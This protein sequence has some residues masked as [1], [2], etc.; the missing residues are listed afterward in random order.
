MKHTDIKNYTL[1]VKHVFGT[2][3]WAEQN[4]NFI[5][6]CKHNCKYCYSKEMAIRFG[7]KTAKDWSNEIIRKKNLNKK[8]RKVE[9]TIMFPS[10]HDITPKHLK[11]SIIFLRNI[12]HEGNKVLIVTKPHIKC[13]EKICDEF[14]DFKDKILF[15]FTIGSCNSNILKFWEPGAPDFKERLNSLKL[16]YNMGYETSVSCEP[17]L[18]GKIDILIN[19]VQKYVTN[20]IW[21][22]K[23]NS[24]LKRLK[25]NCTN[26]KET[27]IQANKLIRLQSD[28]IIL[29]VYRKYKNNSIIKWKESI[30][31]VVGLQVSVEK[32][33]DI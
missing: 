6:G 9:G 22:G 16:A 5:T 27:I 14:V 10:S 23:A 1:D 32:G 26:D 25:T 2:Y 24:L 33:L 28:D 21:L 7:R 4:A 20:S 15:R 30:K 13:I 31:S 18:D 12:L 8:F 3:E 29:K 17:M 11:Q 19:K